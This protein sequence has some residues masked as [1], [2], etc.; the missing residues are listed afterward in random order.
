M[1]G[2]SRSSP[3]CSARAPTPRP[4]P[5]CPLEEWCENSDRAMAT[6]IRPCRNMERSR[7]SRRRLAAPVALSTPSMVDNLKA[8][9]KITK[10]ATCLSL[11]WWWWWCGGV[12]CGWVCVGLL[13]VRVGLCASLGVE[14]DPKVSSRSAL[15]SSHQSST[16]R[17]SVE[18]S[19]LL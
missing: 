12:V 7:R 6:V 9:Q 10:G 13:D 15:P 19:T 1:W 17:Q 16:G 5:S 18:L 2:A 14:S 3:C 11:G 8:Q 4:W